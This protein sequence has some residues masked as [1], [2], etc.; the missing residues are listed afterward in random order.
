[1]DGQRIVL[2]AHRLQH[3]FRL[4]DRFAEAFE[5]LL[6]LADFGDFTYEM[7]R[8]RESNPRIEVLQTPTLPLGYPALL[9][10]ERRSAESPCQRSG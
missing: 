7:R 2:G 8:G 10:T 9:R 1:M 3:C 4:P 5:R 6:K